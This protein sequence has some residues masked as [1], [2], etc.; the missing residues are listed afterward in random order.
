MIMV[1][2]FLSMCGMMNLQAMERDASANNAIVPFTGPNASN[3]TRDAAGRLV[4]K[5]AEAQQVDAAQQVI[6]VSANKRVADPFLSLYFVGGMHAKLQ[7]DI[8]LN[9]K[10]KS[11]E[12]ERAEEREVSQLAV[13]PAMADYDLISISN[14]AVNGSDVSNNQSIDWL[15]LFGFYKEP[16]LAQY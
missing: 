16:R 4:L 3:Y 10:R 7:H 9:D 15:A 1:I 11:E 6:K 12:A 13:V 8:Y 5:Y 2:L 14:E